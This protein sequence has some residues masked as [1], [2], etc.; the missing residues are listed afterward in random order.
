[1]VSDSI[2]VGVS[3]DGL[4]GGEAGQGANAKVTNTS[5]GEITEIGTGALVTLTSD[6]EIVEL[7]LPGGSGY[8]DPAERHL[9][10]ISLDLRDEYVSAE[11]AINRY[12]CDIDNSGTVN[13]GKSTALRQ[14]KSSRKEV[15]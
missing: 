5:T 4:F 14:R 8:G 10:A 7:C 2:G 3:T 6:Q 12:C 13:I 15:A 9:E 1:M 11:E